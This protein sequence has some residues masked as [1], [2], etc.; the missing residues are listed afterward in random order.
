VYCVTLADY[1]YFQGQGDVLELRGEKVI[2]HV[3]CKAPE[4]GE[5]DRQRHSRLQRM[6]NRERRAAAPAQGSAAAARPRV[7]KS[8]RAP[9]G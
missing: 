8:R 1:D 2:Y 3:A 9:C 5:T 6:R 4:D 7:D